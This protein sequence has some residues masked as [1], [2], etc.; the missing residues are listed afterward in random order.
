[1][2]KADVP[3]YKY[4]LKKIPCPAISIL[5]A[6]DYIKRPVKQVE[7]NRDQMMFM[8][9]FTALGGGGGGGNEMHGMKMMKSCSKV[10]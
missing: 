8:K 4:L 7:E 5:T 9:C 3:S 1:M 10:A 2:C 6:P